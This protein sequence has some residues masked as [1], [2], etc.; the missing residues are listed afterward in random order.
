MRF[1]IVAFALIPVAVVASPHPFDVHDLV[2]LERVSDP[3][4]SPNGKRVAYQLRETDYA[5]NKGVNSVWVV[6]LAERNAK[7]AKWTDATLTSGTSPRWSPG[8]RPGDE[9]GRTNVSSLAGR[10]VQGRQWHQ[11]GGTPADESS[12][13]CEQL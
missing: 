12:A 3:Q 6:G 5:A 9:Q 13:R 4:I 11:D 7:P 10:R 8:V 2:M 1:A